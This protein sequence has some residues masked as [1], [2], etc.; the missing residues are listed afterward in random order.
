MPLLS[1]IGVMITSHHF[2]VPFS[3]G[4]KPVKRPV[5]PAHA[6]TKARRASSRSSAGQKVT[7]SALLIFSKSSTSISLRPGSVMSNKRPSRLSTFRQSG[8]LCTIERLYSSLATSACSASLRRVISFR[9]LRVRC[10]VM[11]SIQLITNSSA[12][13]NSPTKEVLWA[14]EKTGSASKTG[15]E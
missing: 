9:R 2:G 5:P 10:R 6:S 15:V 8:E 13:R 14:N 7:Q 1:R 11:A 3:V 4:V 12:L